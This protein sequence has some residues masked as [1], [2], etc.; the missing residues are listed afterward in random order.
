M[1]PGLVS[2][3]Q[4]LDHQSNDLPTELLVMLTLILD[5]Q[6]LIFR[7]RRLYTNV[8]NFRHLSSRKQGTRQAHTIITQ[9]FTLATIPS[10]FGINVEQAFSLSLIV[11]LGGRVV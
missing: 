11:T 2:N 6:N 7:Q 9:L 4:P 8:D 5:K 10:S 1:C 3:H